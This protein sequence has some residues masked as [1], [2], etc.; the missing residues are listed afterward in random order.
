MS[1]L[2]MI[3]SAP[4]EDWPVADVL[5]S[6][7]SDGFPLGKAQAYAELRGPFLVN[8]LNK[9]VRRLETCT[10]AAGLHW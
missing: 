8:D 10:K 2:Q 9:Q 5:L 6:W 4:V 3:L 1:L 7:Y